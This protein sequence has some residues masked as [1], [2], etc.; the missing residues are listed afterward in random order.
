VY[1]KPV[2]EKLNGTW[3]YDALKVLRL[4]YSIDQKSGEKTGPS[5]D[6]LS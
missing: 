6:A 4:L 5:W 3:T 1:L 2:F